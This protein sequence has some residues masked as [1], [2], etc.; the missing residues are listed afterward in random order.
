[1]TAVKY[2]K[3]TPEAAV[4]TISCNAC[5]PDLRLTV[6][7]QASGFISTQREKNDSRHY[8]MEVRV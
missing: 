2:T 5:V 8:C 4:L 6:T 1:M 7:Y 3:W